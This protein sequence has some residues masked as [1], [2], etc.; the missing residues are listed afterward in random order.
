MELS[1]NLEFNQE[2]D[3]FRY[4]CIQPENEG[5]FKTVCRDISFT[6]AQRFVEETRATF[7]NPLLFVSVV[8]QWNVFK[9]KNNL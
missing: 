6:D 8:C 4:Q 2:L 5:G 3:E 1:V 9:L 7:P